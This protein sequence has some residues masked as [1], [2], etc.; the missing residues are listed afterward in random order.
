[1][2]QKIAMQDYSQLV[3]QATKPVVLKFTANW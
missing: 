3:E 1:M 2:L